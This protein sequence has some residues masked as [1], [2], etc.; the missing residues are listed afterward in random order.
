MVREPTV[1]GE[2]A[3]A[4]DCVVPPSLDVQVAVKPVIASLP[5]AFAVNAT[6]AEF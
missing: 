4:S 2:L 6:I 3:P 1:I 5:S